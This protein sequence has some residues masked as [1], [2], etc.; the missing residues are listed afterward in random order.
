MTVVQTWIYFWHCWNK[1]T[2]ALKFLIAFVTVMDAIS[3]TLCA[4]SVYWYLVLNFGNVENLGYIVWS[5]SIQVST[6][7]LV[8]ASVQIYYARRVYIVS[9]SI[10][11]PIIIV[12][13][14]TFSSI[15]GFFFTSKEIAFKDFSKLHSLTWTTCAGMVACALA[16]LLIAASMCWSLY[17]WRTGFARTD[18]II[19]TLMTYIV[20][21]GLLVSVLAVAVII[22]FVVSP[23]S[24]IWAAIYWTM[25][26][27]YVNSLLAM[28][29]SRDYVCNRSTTDD[30]PENA[31]KLSSIRFEPSRDAYGSKAGVSVT[32]HRSTP[33][34]FGRN[35]S[36]PDEEP[37]F[38]VAKP[39]ATITAFEN[40]D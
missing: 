24:M 37:A 13:L 8:D 40:Q 31:T 6:S 27:C 19:M 14:V 10:I 36:D 39:G 15:L 29:N 28:L 18:S 23:A 25:S 2:K 5:M 34:D 38:D 1:D 4:Y 7:I 12:A 35:K 9:K 26:K 33:M 32:V 11:C 21:S 20:N 30:H 22:N 17:R 16:D 3:T